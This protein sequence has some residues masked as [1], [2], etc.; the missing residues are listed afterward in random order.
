MFPVAT[1]RPL[2]SRL[3]GWSLAL[4]DQGL[5]SAAT[6]ALSLVVARSAGPD[7]LARFSLA[8]AVTLFL[9]SLH[10]GLVSAPLTSLAA[11]LP[12][13]ERDAHLA[14]LAGWHRL[15]GWL[16][17][18]LAGL[19]GMLATGVAAPGERL[20]WGLLAGL[21]V[22]AAAGRAGI[23]FRRRRAYLCAEPAQAAAVS[24][25]AHVPALLLA[26]ATVLGLTCGAELALG[27]LAAGAVLGCWLIPVGRSQPAAAQ[28]V[29]RAHWRLGRWHVASLLVLW[30]TNYAFGWYLAGRGDLREAGYLHVART[31]LGLPLAALLAFDAWFQPRGREAWVAAGG[32]GLARVALRHG[33]LAAAVA[34]PCAAVL[35]WGAQPV[36]VVAFGAD[37]EAAAPA[38]ALG[39]WCAVLA[40]PDRLLGLVI[41]ARQ[42][43]EA[44]AAGFV[45]CLGLTCWLLPLWA[46]EGAVGCARL[47]AVNAAAMVV[48]PGLWLAA[49]WR[50]A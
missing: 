22:L 37:M 41:A 3:P 46:A 15:G 2:L 10:Q 16:A 8:F 39:A 13:A 28:P 27:V 33:A 29:A 21:A 31:L 24:G 17:L 32:P 20:I 38:V 48:V 1:P 14:R 11:G 40:V 6:F 34:L 43:P 35:W 4:V 5:A 7:A 45:A 23:E 9:G 26:G 19:A 49:T 44:T 42:R 30:A 36:T 47:L 50:R 12:A 18:P 25:W